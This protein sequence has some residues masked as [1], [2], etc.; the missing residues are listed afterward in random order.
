MIASHSK[1]SLQTINFRINDIK[2]EPKKG[3][4]WVNGDFHSVEPKVMAV[5][6]ELAAK[7]NE[8]IE[9]ELLFSQVWPSSVFSPNSVRRCI[10]ELRKLFAQDRRTQNIITTHPKK[11]YSLDADIKL[12]E[13][14]LKN[15]RKLAY[16][17]QA[18]QGVVLVTL[19]LLAMIVFYTVRNSA[20][21][22]G[23]ASKK[24]NVVEQ[25]PITTSPSLDFNGKYSPNG[26]KIAFIR[27]SIGDVSKSL[28]LKDLDTEDERQISPENIN[29]SEFSWSP[30]GKSISYFDTSS[31]LY[32]LSLNSLNSTKQLATLG[33]VNRISA[34]EWGLDEKIYFL[35]QIIKNN[36]LTQRLSVLD[37]NKADISHIHNFEPGYWPYAITMSVKAQKIAI[38]GFN[39]NG[40][41]QI[42][43]WNTKTSQIST[44]ASLNQNRYFIDYHPTLNQIL[45]SDGRSLSY[46][47]ENGKQNAIN[48][49]HYDFI[50]FP[51]YAPNSDGILISHGK[52]DIDIHA[53]PID[54]KEDRLINSKNIVLIDTNNTDRAAV[55]SPDKRKLVFISHRKGYPQ[56]Y[57]FDLET[58]KTSL[59]FN[60]D[61]KL[62]GLSEPVWHPGNSKIA[63]AVYDRPYVVEIGTTGSVLYSSEQNELKSIGVPNQWESGDN[64]ILRVRSSR[65]EKENLIGLDKGSMQLFLVKAASTNANNK[66]LDYLS[67][68]QHKSVLIRTSDENKNIQI[69]DTIYESNNYYL[70][71][72]PSELIEQENIRV[73]QLWRV[74]DGADDTKFLGRLP[75]S[76]EG[77]V[78]LTDT[79]LIYEVSSVQKSL[80]RLEMN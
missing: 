77:L 29:V 67:K 39:Q 45:L 70:L 8:V 73:K 15:K 21:E 38:A 16:Y 40:I 1:P 41:S 76:V 31:T 22:F 19:S 71:V 51:Q 64:N 74:T 58:R 7:P 79:H 9:Q 25:T 24:V 47:D 63:F 48:F 57:L 50:Q 52:Y 54:K 5:L 72:Q 11:G 18:T 35:T 69:I 13:S 56:L 17:K 46:V 61:N 28:W 66:Q 62:L 4:I 30:D 42:R 78:G 80:V 37:L 44:L 12:E 2:V 3:R 6:V 34:F 53:A 60:N 10:A 23:D 14:H 43:V 33:D 55:I 65:S 26:T 36:E 20:T 75:N 32:V 49:E 59:L 27:S 68:T